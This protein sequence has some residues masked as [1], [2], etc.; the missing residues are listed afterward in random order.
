MFGFGKWRTERQGEVFISLEV[1]LWGLFPVVTVLSFRGIPPLI[2][3]AWSTLFSAVFFAIVLTVRRSWGELRNTEALKDI[4]IATLLTGVLYYGLYFSGLQHTTAGNASLIA[5]SETLFSFLF[6]NLWKKESFSFAHGAGVMLMLLGAGAVLYP[7][8]HGLQLGDV[9]I[10]IASA[11]APFG[12]FFQRRARRLV[13]SESILFLRSAISAIV[14]F[15]FAGMTHANF[16]A[17]DIRG[18]LLALCINGFFL[19]GLSK[20]L[21]IEGIHRISVTKASALNVI[22]PLMTLLFAWMLLGDV[23][24]KY[25][26]LS[27]IPMFFGIVLLSSKTKSAK[28]SVSNV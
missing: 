8:V 24:T 11:V 20:F 5:L 13:R 15:L 22:A 6:F 4:L 14:I 23:P 7:N 16:T 9:L 17:I 26:L 27:F 10:L 1:I 18:S 3:L 21:W 19:L 25:Q 28:G 12:N 2:S